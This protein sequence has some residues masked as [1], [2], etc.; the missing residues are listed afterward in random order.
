MFGLH[1]NAE[2]GYLTL[3][4]DN[5]FETILSLQ[6]GDISGGSESGGASVKQDILSQILNTLPKEFD[7]LDIDE[8]AEEVL[9]GDEAPYVIVIMQE[10]AA[11]NKLLFEIRRSLEE[12]QKGVDGALNMTDAMEDLSVAL[13]LRQVP[14]RNP[15]HKCSWERLA[16]WSKKTLL[17]WYEDLKRRVQQLQIWSSN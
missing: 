17:P 6:G 3:T 2:I 9:N 10:C 13:S 5:M 8:R 4:A 16:W 11:M 1:P 12:L 14:G 15:F 7:L